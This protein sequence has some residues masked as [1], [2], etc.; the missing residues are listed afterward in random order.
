[1]ILRNTQQILNYTYF[2]K[3]KLKGINLINTNKLR[4]TYD[5]PLEIQ[6][7][8][9]FFFFFFFSSF[10]LLYFSLLSLKMGSST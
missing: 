4:N 7:S 2:Q 8:N 9:F 1:M 3:S 5:I 10:S 6:I